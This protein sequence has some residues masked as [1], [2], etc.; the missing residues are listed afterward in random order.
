MTLESVGVLLAAILAAAGIL[1]LALKT[2]RKAWKGL[3]NL[4]HLVDELLGIEARGSRP[5]V[6]GWAARL[7][8]IQEDLG[9]VK[10]QVFPNGGSSLRDAVDG[11]SDRLDSHLAEAAEAQRL[12]A[13]HVTAGG[14]HVAVPPGGSLTVTPST[15]PVPPAPK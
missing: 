3:R 7:D 4:G 2:A 6:P 9:K 8:Q 11:L 5:A 13:D 10:A 1:G 15:G 14:V 12:F